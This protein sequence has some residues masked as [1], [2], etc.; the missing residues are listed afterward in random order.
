VSFE[1]IAYEVAGGVATI[2]LDRPEKLN[3]LRMQTYEELAA[4]LRRAGAD[5][6]AGVVVLAGAGRAFCAGGDLEMAQTMLTSEAAGR[7]HYFGRMIESSSR[8][9]ALGKPVICAVQGACVGGGAELALFA[10]LVLADETAFFVFNGTAIGGCS[11]WGAPQLL[12]VLVGMRR[13][14]EILYLSRKVK[15]DEAERIGLITRAVPAGELEAATRET[16]ERIL[17]L[18]EEG[19][20]LTKAALRS[21]KEQLLATMTA[22]AEMNVA[23][24]GKP[25]LHAAFDAFLEG[26][27]MSW[28][29]LR[30]GFRPEPA[31]TTG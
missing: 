16:C 10:D 9:L 27:S 11:W 21:T 23:A 31:G 12:P 6:T 20:R 19:V 22:A 17:D 7:D 29:E 28:R 1:D 26:R 13:A 2:T 25:D 18:S 4:A 30:P 15:A 5:E 14:E 8:M 3:A 24:L